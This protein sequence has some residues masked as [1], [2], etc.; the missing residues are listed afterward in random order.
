MNCITNLKQGLDSRVVGS[1]FMLTSVV[2][3]HLHNEGEKNMAQKPDNPA[4]RNP[5]IAEVSPN[6]R[7]DLSVICCTKQRI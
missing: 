5:Y 2:Q 1:Q 7:Q 6:P 3:M 4:S